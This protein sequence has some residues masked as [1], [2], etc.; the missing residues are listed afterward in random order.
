MDSSQVA[1]EAVISLRWRRA[2][3]KAL[4]MLAMA[5]DFSGIAYAAILDLSLPRRQQCTFV[6]GAEPTT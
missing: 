5:A 3:T 2:Q 6:G 1:L 4:L